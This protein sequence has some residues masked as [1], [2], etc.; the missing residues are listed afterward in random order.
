MISVRTKR[1]G[2]LGWPISHSLSPRVH[3]FWLDKYGIDGVYKPLAVKPKDLEQT[4]KALA[5]DGY[6]GFNLTVPHKE[7]AMLLM[8][9]VDRT[10]K[11]IGAINTVVVQDGKKLLG[12]NTDSTGFLENL[13]SNLANVS[14]LL[15]KAAVIGAGGAARAVCA[16]LID[17][18]ALEIRLINRTRARAEIMARHMGGPINVIPWEQRAAALDGVTLLVNASSLGMTGQP[19]LDLDISRLSREA[20]VNDIVYSPLETPLLKKARKRGNVAVDGLGMLLHQARPAFAAWFG[21][22]P[23]VTDELRSHVLSGLV[24]NQ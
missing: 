4:I 20:V 1:A 6:A 11:R 19:S 9:E 22:Q 10:A 2:V 8:D 16:A 15:G 12:W 7:T 5:D 17:H 24:K 3:G 14:P 21:V 18:G 23:S 13:K